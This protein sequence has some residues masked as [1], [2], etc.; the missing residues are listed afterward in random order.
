MS[1]SYYK[2]IEKNGIKI[3]IMSWN[4]ES[5]RLCETLD[6]MKKEYNRSAGVLG[7]KNIEQWYDGDIADF[8]EQ[9]KHQ[10]QEAESPDLVVIGFQEDAFPGSYFH[11]HLLQD[12]MPKIGY[13]FIKRTKLKGVGVTT[14]KAIQNLDL[15]TRGLRMSIYAKKGLSEIIHASE[16]DLRDNLGY[17]GQLTY[18]CSGFNQ[19]TRGK[20]AIASYIIVPTV[21]TFAFVC[22]HLPYHAKSL[23]DSRENKDNMIRQDALSYSNVSYNDIL[24]TFVKNVHP[25]PDYV[26]FF[27]DFNYRIQYPGKASGLADMIVQNNDGIPLFNDLY[28]NYDEMLNQMKLGTIYGMLEGVNNEG[29][30]FI[31]TCKLVKYRDNCVTLTDIDSIDYYKIGKYD[32]RMP[33]WCDRILY[34]KYNKQVMF[35]LECISYHNF[36]VG[37]IIAKSDHSAVIGIYSLKYSPLVT[38]HI[39]PNAKFSLNQ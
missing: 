34:Y 19:L 31:P 6:P 18:I 7:I 3:F 20:G 37:K 15:M 27:G 22:T 4:T 10:I 2:I 12:E 39:S 8:F 32:Q 1:N 9:I 13:D 16:I 11:S 38:N 14:Y 25:N 24:R 26:F 29:P 5:T 28:Q 21:G 30:M 35:N 17:D 33:S 23:I 36:D